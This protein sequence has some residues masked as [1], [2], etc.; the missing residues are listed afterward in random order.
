M[1]FFGQNYLVYI[2]PLVVYPGVGAGKVSLVTPSQPGTKTGA[3]ESER[4]DLDNPL[5]DRQGERGSP[6]DHASRFSPS[7]QS[8]RVASRRNSQRRD[9]LVPR[10]TPRKHLIRTE[11]ERR[12]QDP[13][14]NGQALSHASWNRVV[15]M[16]GPGRGQVGLAHTGDAWRIPRLTMQSDSAKEGLR[17][18]PAPT[19]PRDKGETH[20][21]FTVHF[22]RRMLP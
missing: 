21:S 19:S 14:A 20:R 3:V 10:R 2:Y 4:R 7:R 8:S 22:H 18:A 9:R 17:V 12:L 15:K 5:T 16:E 13:D 6:A 1:V 11:H